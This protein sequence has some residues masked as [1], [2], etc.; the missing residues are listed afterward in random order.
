MF[1]NNL[2]ITDCYV[3][4]VKIMT[5]H[6]QLHSCHILN[7]YRI[8]YASMKS[9]SVNHTQYSRGLRVSV[10]QCWANFE[11][12]GHCRKLFSFI[13]LFFKTLFFLQMTYKQVYMIIFGNSWDLLILSFWVLNEIKNLR[14]LNTLPGKTES[15]Y[16]KEEKYINRWTFDWQNIRQ[17]L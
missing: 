11:T 13:Y 17:V 3:L 8:I 16:M 2:L 12:A 4:S 15:N 5:R 14:V 9:V 10:Q 7:C 6:C 1:F